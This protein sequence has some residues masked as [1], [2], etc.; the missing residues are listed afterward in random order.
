MSANITAPSRSSVS[1]TNRASASVKRSSREARR[2]SFTDSS[3]VSKAT[4]FGRICEC[5]KL[6]NEK[7]SKERTDIERIAF[8]ERITC[9]LVLH[10]DVPQAALETLRDAL[11]KHKLLQAPNH[12][13]RRPKR[14][15]FSNIFDFFLLVQ[16]FTG[17]VCCS[18]SVRRCFALWSIDI[19]SAPRLTPALCSPSSV[20]LLPPNKTSLSGYFFNFFF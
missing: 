8:K 17:S 16:I 11:P 9:F 1:S 19:D 15:F 5:E 13:H 10:R 7:A 3:R 12:H 2:A 18:I 4:L 6:R 14:S 20:S